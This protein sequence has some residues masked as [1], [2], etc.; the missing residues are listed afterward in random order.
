[1]KVAVKDACVL[2]GL[3][4]AGLLDVWFQLGIETHTTDLVIRQVKQLNQWRII[5][6]FIQAG[7]LKVATMTGTELE[8]MFVEYAHL[9]IGVEDKTVLFLAVKLDA[10]LVTGDRTVRIEGIKRKLEVRGVLWILDELI[11]RGLLA[12]KLAA[13]KLGL[14]LKEG[15]FLP[16]DESK[17]R[18]DQW[19]K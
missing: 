6:G 8:Q 13:V 11:N 7:M 15:A 10:I 17:K 16:P 1:M 18:L 3:A 9:K 12:K 19:E 5:T 14:M 2:I 4:N